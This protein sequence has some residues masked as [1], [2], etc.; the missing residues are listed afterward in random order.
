MR[1]LSNDIVIQKNKNGM[2]YLQFKKLLELNVKHAYALK[3]DFFLNVPK[4]S[5]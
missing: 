5:F 3:G 4:V 2:N 1:D